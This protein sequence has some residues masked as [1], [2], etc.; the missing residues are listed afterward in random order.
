MR[1]V[2]LGPPGAGKG[3]QSKRLIAKLRIPQISTGDM[4]RAAVRAGTA[5]G[6]EAKGY[7]DSGDLVPDEL[8]VRMVAERLR[9]D[10]C[11]SGYLLDGFPRNVAQGRALSD[12]LQSRSEKLD[13]AIS[14]Q[15]GEADLVERISGRRVCSTC[16]AAYHVRYAAPAVEGVCDACSGEVV[17]RADD[18]PDTVRSR[19]AVY[20]ESTEPLEAFY[21]DLGML[22]LVDGTGTPG[23]VEQRVFG[24][25][26][27]GESPSVT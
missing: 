12:A 23:A 10:D 18:Q 11:R 17:Q 24:V 7:M 3:T 2:L 22:R 19:L 6:V 27:M 5:L 20:R 9:Q 16:G 4:L 13:L 14:L 1:I 25:I 26:E 15:V 21:G 8:V